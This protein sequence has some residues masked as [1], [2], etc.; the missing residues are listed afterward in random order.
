MKLGPLFI[1]TCLLA[2]SAAGCSRFGRISECRGLAQTVNE[3]M[4][5]LE[6]V[7]KGKDTPETF[8]KLSKGYTQ[9]ADE[10]AALPVAQGAASAHVAEYVANLRAAAKSSHE[11]SEALKAGARTEAQ[12]KELDRTGRKDKLSAQK[13]DAYCH[14]P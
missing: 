9:L 7:S 11:M 10:V 14:A 13:L 3:H 8:A 6:A 5:E 4:E 12:R 1:S 2:A